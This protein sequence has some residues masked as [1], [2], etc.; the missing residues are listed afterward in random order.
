MRDEGTDRRRQGG[1][2]AG[3][4]RRPAAGG[5]ED[6]GSAITGR[7]AVLAALEAGRPLHRILLGEGAGGSGIARILAMARQAGVPVQ[8]APGAVLT[9]A[10]GG[11]HH[12]G[13]VALAA[14]RPYVQPEDLLEVARARGEVP[15]LVALAHVQ[16]PGNLGAIVRSAEVLGAH[17]VMIPARR[18]AGLTVGAEKAAA[19]ALEFLQVARVT[20]MGTALLDLGNRG[21]WVVGAEADGE[22]WP[23]EAD[24]TGPLV[25]VLGGEDR[26]LGRPERKVCHQVVRIP[27]YGRIPSLNVAAAAAILLYEVVR[28]RQECPGGQ[29]RQDSSAGNDRQ[30]RG[31]SGYGT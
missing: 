19:G 23:W 8:R 3:P 21:L 5:D 6:A 13:V 11:P 25:L 4:D 20:N 2:H 24:L 26:G 16:D 17:G 31:G 29:D 27:R 10:G 15:L 18:A 28:Q 12:Q 22:V 7:Q 30:G 1:P 14:R 9:A